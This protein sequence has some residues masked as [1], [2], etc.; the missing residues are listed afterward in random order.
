MGRIKIAFDFDGVLN[1]LPKPIERFMRSFRPNSIINKNYLLTEIIF[2][3]IVRLPIVL[4]GRLLDY[5]P[6]NTAII[7]GRCTRVNEIKKKLVKLGFN[8]LHFRND[9][10]IKETS[11]KIHKCKELGIKIFFEDRLYVIERLRA[12]GIIGVDIREWEKQ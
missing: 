2:N 8:N 4:D 7:S 1:R 10:S 6:R 12:N 3:I 9:I 5:I 11:F